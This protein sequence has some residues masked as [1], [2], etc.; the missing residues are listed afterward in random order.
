MNDNS[1]KQPDKSSSTETDTPTNGPAPTSLS[2]PQKLSRAR[3]RYGKPFKPEIN[4]K[5]STPPSFLLQHITKLQ[6]EAAA[7]KITDIRRFKKT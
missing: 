1:S 2:N 4:I 6:E 5:R 7:D 3:Q